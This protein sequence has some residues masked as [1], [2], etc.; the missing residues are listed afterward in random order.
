MGSIRIVAGPPSRA[1]GLVIVCALVVALVAACGGGAS[2]AATG[3]TGG[4]AAT[5]AGGGAATPPP[6]GGSTPPGGGSSADGKV[7]GDVCGLLTPDELKTQLGVDF[8]QGTVKQVSGSTANCDWETSSGLS[9]ALVS[10]TVEEFDEGQWKIAKKVEGA[11]PQSGLGD[12]ALFGFL[13][14]LYVKKDNL[15]FTIQVVLMPAPTGSLDNA[16]IELA[17]LVLSRL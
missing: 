2:P 17:K 12:D 4:G 1:P 6:G 5:P 7:V 3:S 11:R 10:L 8:P 9:G 13:D 15:D 14:V 16:K